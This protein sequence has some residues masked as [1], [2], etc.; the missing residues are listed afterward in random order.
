MWL[1]YSWF[2]DRIVGVGTS[3]GGRSCKSG[4]FGSRRCESGLGL[5]DR[6]SA[7]E[8]KGLREAAALA[9]VAR[10]F[11]GNTVRPARVGRDRDGWRFCRLA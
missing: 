11:R 1:D 10:R 8:R 5:L 4:L 9:D 7:K 6:E 2:R 3:V